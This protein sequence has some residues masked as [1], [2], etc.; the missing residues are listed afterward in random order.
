MRSTQK[1]LNPFHILSPSFQ[2]GVIPF[3]VHRRLLTM[4]SSV[5]PGFLCCAFLALAV[6]S[7]HLGSTS[8]GVTLP[9]PTSAARDTQGHQRWSRG[10]LCFQD[11]CACYKE[12]ANCSHNDGSLSF[13]P[14]LNFRRPIRRL[15]FGDN[16]LTSIPTDDFFKNVSG[17][18]V[19]DLQNNDLKEISPGAFRPLTNLSELILDSNKLKYDTLLSVFSAKTLRKL[20][21]R[22]M[23]LGTMPSGYFF[24]KLMPPQFFLI[25]LSDNS[26]KCL[27]LSEFQ[28]FPRLKSLFARSSRIY[29]VYVSAIPSLRVL[30]LQDNALHDFLDTCTENGS[31]LFPNLRILDL[32][33][34]KFSGFKGKQICLPKLHTLSL[35]KNNI[36]HIKTDMFGGHRFPRLRQ[37]NLGDITSIKAID[38]FAFRNPRLRF[39]GLNRCQIRFSDVS[40]NPL[41][42][43]ESPRLV[44][45]QLDHNF[46]AGL[47]DE[48][49]SQ[50]FGSVKNLTRLYLGKCDIHSISKRA[51]AT[52][53]R[54]LSELYLHRNKIADLPDGVFDSL[55]SLQKLTLGLNQLHTVQE[56]LFSPELRGRL[57]H[58]DLSGNPFICDCNL[59]WLQKWFV[60]SSSLFDNYTHYTCNNLNSIDLVDFALKEEGCFFSQDTLKAMIGCVVLFVVSLVGLA[61]VYQYRWHIRLKLTFRNINDFRSRRLE[62]SVAE[63]DIF[64]SCAEEDQSWVEQNLVPH[65]EGRLGLRLCLQDRDTRPN[66]P[67]IKNILEGLE[68]SSEIMTVFSKHYAQDPMCQFELDVC[69]T[70]VVDYNER[71]VVVCVGDVTPR[72]LTST[73]MAVMN[74]TMYIQWRYEPGTRKMFWKRLQLCLR[75]M[76]RRRPKRVHPDRPVTNTT[77]V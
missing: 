21:A 60:A 41:C 3:V 54:R 58:L 5:K 7:G 19:L 43:A 35:N 6:C 49:F 20:S 56:S 67:V 69:L 70:E 26:L 38:E 11:K 25:D 61:V 64:V 71:L 75:G 40:V 24:R 29:R 57:V 4:E 37:L 22:N 2:G 47:L 59:L 63:Y 72:D 23:S 15:V 53:M 52:G 66:K 39:L 32:I 17:V 50:L 18:R 1:S 76:E 31:S 73:M 62:N 74:T 55:N 51:F 13:I 46:L 9:S 44:Q 77:S 28:A 42:F 12:V 68:S 8:Y 33:D 30:R 48:K 27:N 10:K 65:L 45:L 14:K 16:N 36:K 34:N